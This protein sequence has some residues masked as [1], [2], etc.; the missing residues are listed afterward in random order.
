M[1][2][3][4]ASRVYIPAI[5]GAYRFEKERNDKV[6]L[7]QIRQH[8]PTLSSYAIR[9]CLWAHGIEEDF[10]D[11]HGALPIASYIVHD[12]YVR[13]LKELGY[14]PT[15]RDLRLGMFSISV[16][17]H[18]TIYLACIRKIDY[19]THAGRT[20]WLC[21]GGDAPLRYLEKKR[22]LDQGPIVDAD[23]VK[24]MAPADFEDLCSAAYDTLCECAKG[25]QESKSNYVDKFSESISCG[26]D[27]ETRIAKEILEKYKNAK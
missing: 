20:A 13:Y 17:F 16:V 9:E 21:P 26:H 4:C 15:I 10:P 25:P 8:L 5:I 23:V 14:S 24:A 1:K 18:A 3:S 22:Y 7:R 19:L 12:M 6:T 11:G 27:Y 2:Q